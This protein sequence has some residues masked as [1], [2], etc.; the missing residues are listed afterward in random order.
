MPP[1]A[2]FYSQNGPRNLNPSWVHFCLLC[3]PTNLHIPPPPKKKNLFFK[4]HTLPN[5]TKCWQQLGLKANLSFFLST[6]ATPSTHLPNTP[7]LKVLPPPANSRSEVL[8]RGCFRE[9]TYLGLVATIRFSPFTGEWFTDFLFI[10]GL[11]FPQQE[12]SLCPFTSSLGAN[13]S[14]ICSIHANTFTPFMRMVAAKCLG[15][16]KGHV[17]KMVS[18]VGTCDRPVSPQ[19]WKVAQK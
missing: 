6:A 4:M 14:L 5:L 13:A 2:F 19:K 1:L 17:Q 8:E 7:C 11:S 16:G 10:H 15:K 12:G 3:F 18:P 9:G